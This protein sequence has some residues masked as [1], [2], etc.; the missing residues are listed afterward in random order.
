MRAREQRL[1]RE[2]AKLKET[3][4][5]KDRSIEKWKKRYYRSE[6][7]SDRTSPLR[8]RVQ[9]IERQGK[10]V[11]R[12][13]IL[14]GEVIKEHLSLKKADMKSER[15]KRI[16]SQ[17][18]S[19]KIIKK[20][21]LG[22]N[23]AK[24]VSPY[25]Q[26]KYRNNTSLILS[27]NTTKRSLFAETSRHR[28]QEF[29]ERD[30]NSA[31][32]PGIK[33]CFKKNKKFYRKRY[34]LDTMEN[35]YKKYNAEEPM[36]ISRGLFHR[37]KPFWIVQKKESQRDSCLCKTHDNFDLIVRKLKSVGMIGTASRNEVVTQVVCDTSNRAC[38]YRQCP[39]CKTKG[40]SVKGSSAQ[41]VYEQWV[42]EKI[43]RP[44]AKGKMYEVQL[45]TKKK[46]ITTTQELAEEF[47]SQLPVYMKHVY[48]TSHQFQ[49][50]AK[51]KKNL[52]RSEV[53]VVMDFS[54]NYKCKYASEIQSVHFGA[55]K[56]QISMHTGAY[57]YRTK[58]G[59]LECVSFC[60]VS[61][62]LR[63]DASAVWAH[64]KP[65]LKH[66]QDKLPHVKVL[67]FQ[68]D[69]PSTQY[70]NKS[71]FYLLRHYCKELN[72]SL[73]SYT[74]TTPGHGKSCTDGTRGTV[75]CLCDR[76][77][78]QGHDVLSAADMIEVISRAGSKVQMF[79]ITT[80]DIETV[81]KVLQKVDP[82]PQ[83]KKTFQLI[84]T[85]QREDRIFTNTLACLDCLNNP[86]CQHYVINKSGFV[87][88]PSKTIQKNGRRVV[89]RKPN[90][91]S[92]CQVDAAPTSQKKEKVPMIRG[93][94]KNKEKI[95][96]E[97]K[98]KRKT[99]RVNNI[100]RKQ[101]KKNIVVKS[102]KKV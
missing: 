55:S 21:R 77:V 20:Y 65:V 17:I 15:E 11:V 57:Y 69:G 84:W 8:K 72:L 39:S 25:E 61:E 58:D 60:S 53:H 80:E 91:K 73:G 70:K 59:E 48:D 87:F 27:R 45:T 89:E 30:E 99:E 37:L 49:F 74:F 1:R 101:C 2:I 54:E 19:G 32:A 44:G 68:S 16:F 75:K 67:H 26:R 85:D 3:I 95:V 81:D 92:S 97:T 63:H 36:K 43:V 102:K 90:G 5:L 41:V 42:T 93:V 100:N 33:D 50:L 31:M 35:L 52:K 79:L 86:P 88:K 10:D 78:L 56:K 47:N 96:L 38:M 46:K 22:K 64:L 23:L 82:I 29:L 83:T 6:K 13:H 28:V 12:K 71:N 9:E 14:F 40:I 18:L 94:K 4:K 51:L 62:N 34:L 7:T 66:I 76:Y 24:F 98:T